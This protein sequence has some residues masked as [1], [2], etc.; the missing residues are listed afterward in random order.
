[1]GREC[2]AGSLGSTNATSMSSDL[3]IKE[4][5]RDVAKKVLFGGGGSRV[6]HAM[7]RHM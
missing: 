1:M 2:E 5:K 6:L 7:C 3:G 4:R